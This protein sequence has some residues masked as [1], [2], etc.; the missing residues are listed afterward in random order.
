MDTD[1]IYAFALAH[2]KG[3]MKQKTF[4]IVPDCANSEEGVAEDFLFWGREL[5][6]EAEWEFSW[7][8]YMY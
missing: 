2:A 8:R 3:I 4:F 6:C 1:S 5:H 7:L